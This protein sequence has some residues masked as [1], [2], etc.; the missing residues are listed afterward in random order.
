MNYC[1][2]DAGVLD[3]GK[4]YFCDFTNKYYST[5]QECYNNCGLTFSKN[6]GSVL[7]HIS[8]VEFTFLLGI[9]AVLLAVAFFIAFHIS[10][11]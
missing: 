6:G 10:H 7:I 9:W 3:V 4:R 1:V 8:N 5:Y 2:Y 11:D